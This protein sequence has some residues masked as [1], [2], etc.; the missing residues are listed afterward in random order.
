M[1]TC[2]VGTRHPSHITKDFVMHSSGDII[3]KD[4]IEEQWEKEKRL[5]QGDACL[6][7]RRKQISRRGAEVRITDR[8]L[9]DQS[10]IT[11]DAASGGDR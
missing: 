11:F 10:G 9:A 7:K 4:E 1:E 3:F 6:S 8:E 5:L 2:L